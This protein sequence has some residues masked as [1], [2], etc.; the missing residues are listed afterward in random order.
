MTRNTPK[1]EPLNNS[2]F[3][4]LITGDSMNY[5]NGLFNVK[6]GKDHIKGQINRC[7]MIDNEKE[8]IILMDSWNRY[9]ILQ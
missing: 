6:Q 7:N 2:I 3:K 1:N 5:A 4:E 8:N 9:L